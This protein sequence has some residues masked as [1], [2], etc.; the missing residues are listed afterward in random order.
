ME[1]FELKEIEERVILVGV[2]ENNGEDTEESLQELAELARTAGAETV[3]SLIQ[4]R[5]AIHPGTYIGKGK[6]EELRAMADML[7]ATGIVCDDELSPAQLRNL[8]QEL[9]MKVMD[10][11][12]IILDIF[13]AR[14]ST[15]EGKIQVELAQLKYRQARLVGLRDSLSR[16]GGGIG[17][18][19]PGEKKLEMDRRLIKDRIAQLNREL[20]DVKRHREVT[21]AKRS[22]NKAP[23]AAIVG[24]T[25]AGKSTLLNTLTGAGVLQEDKLFATLDPTTRMLEMEG[26]AQILLTDTVGFIRKL[27]HHLIEAFRSTLEEAKY[28]DIILHVVDASNPQMEKQM[29]VVYQTLANLGVKDKTMVTLFNKQDRIAEKENL[30]DFKADYCLKISAKTGEG[31]EEMKSL[32]EKLLRERSILIERLYPY[33]QAG[34]IQ[35]IRKHGQLLEEEYRPEGIYVKAYVP[36]E[37][38]GTVAL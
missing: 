36:V 32:L 12:L 27:P 14:A 17:T 25:N 23:V 21:R 3:G 19:G 6:I 1:A 33:G 10:R 26:G 37:I 9:D 18:R 31:L 2:Q 7:D 20:A 34:L 15:N 16:L 4:N 22:K 24:Y 35:L 13:A 11:T 8:E 5:E 29:Y 38:Y 28:A 30:R